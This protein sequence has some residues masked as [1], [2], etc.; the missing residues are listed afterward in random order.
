[1]LKCSSGGFTLSLILIESWL[2][3]RPLV[4]EGCVFSGAHL[5]LHTL[6]MFSLEQSSGFVLS[7]SFIQSTTS[8]DVC[9]WGLC[10]VETSNCVQVLTI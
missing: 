9:V 6:H 3:V 4:D 8:S 10:P 7:F 5:I 1:M 2:G